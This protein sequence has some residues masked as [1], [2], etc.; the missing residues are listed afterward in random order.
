M[1]RKTHLLCII[2][3]KDIS[4]VSCRNCDIDLLSILDLSLADQGRICIYIIYDLR[5]QTSDIDRVCRRE[6]ITC[7]IKLCFQLLVIKHFLYSS[8]GIIK[9]AGNS[10]Y[11]GIISLLG[12]H[13]LLLNR[14]YTVLRIKDNDLCA[15]YICKACHGSLSCI[16]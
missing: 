8:L 14:A 1:Y 9:I 6:L 12:N 15:R 11:V 13:L 3:S 5:N 2:C 16:P 7:L 10:H 4:K